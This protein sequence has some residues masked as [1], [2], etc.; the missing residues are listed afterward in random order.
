MRAVAVDNILH[1][2]YINESVPA[3]YLNYNGDWSI[4]QCAVALNQCALTLRL[5]VYSR[6]FL[7]RL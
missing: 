1:A 5:D 2:I 7:G 3:A 4:E 6:G